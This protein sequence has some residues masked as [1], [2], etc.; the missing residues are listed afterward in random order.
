MG[1]QFEEVQRFRQLWVWAITLLLAAGATAYAAGTLF[2]KYILGALQHKPTA[3]T[4]QMFVA[5]AATAV[6][7]GLMALMYAARL[8]VSLSRDAVV[9]VFYPFTREHRVPLVQI[10]R[11]EIREYQPLGDH[12]GWGVR[13]VGGMRTYTA[14][15]TRAIMLTLKSGDEVLIGTQRPTEWHRALTAALSRADDL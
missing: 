11:C 4:V 13:V 10:A 14:S 3:V 2:E 6:L 7:W 5:M 8:V 12:G 9:I 15:G 1:A